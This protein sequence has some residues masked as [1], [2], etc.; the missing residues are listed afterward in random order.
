MKKN[1][2]FKFMLLLFA[3]VVGCSN[4]W[5]DEYELYSGTIT[6]GDY[7]IVYDVVAMKNTVSSSRLDYQSVTISNNKISNPGAAIVWHIAASGNY[8]TIYNANVNK[9][10]ASTGAKSKAQ[11]L[12]SG[13]DD[14]SLWTVSGTSTY[15]F[16]NKKN[17]AN[18]VNKN[19][20][21]NSGY[22]FACYATSTGGALSLYKKVEATGA[23]TTVTID[24]SELTNTNKFFGT[25]AGTLTAAVTVTSGG[26][27]VDG[28]TVTWSSGDEDVA[29]VDE[30]GVVTL[31]GEGS[32]TITAS[33][34]GETGVYKSS[35]AEYVLNVTDE[36]PFNY[37][38]WSENFGT[39]SEGDIPSGGTYS[40]VCVNGAT[41]TQIYEANMAGGT[42]PELLVNKNGGT[43][44]AT[45]PLDNI[46]GNLKLKFK[47]NAYA[48]SVSTSTDGISISGDY[49]FNTAGEHTVTFTG[50][51]PSKTSIV[52]KF[53][54]GSSN[55][56][57]DDITLKGAIPGDNN[58]ELTEDFTIPTGTTFDITS[59]FII[60]DGVTLTVNG[61]LENDDPANLII[62]DG[63]QLICN[64]PVN[65]T[66]QKGI[67]AAVVWGVPGAD[68]WYFIASPVDGYETSNVIITGTSDTD[69]YSFDE[70]SGYW[71]NGQGTEHPF[72]TLNRGQGY[73]YANKTGD[74]LS[75]LGT[76]PATNTNI[77]KTLSYAGNGD[78][79]GFNLMGNPFT[80]N[81][82]NDNVKIQYGETQTSLTT[83][84]IV[85]NGTELATMELSSNPIK[86]GRGFLIQADKDGQKLVF[87]PGAKR[88]ETIN[89]PSF[90]RIEAGD[91]DFMDR[92]YVQFGQGN[93]L[94]KMT[95]N[96]NVSHV[97]VMSEG[98]DYAAA[99]IQEAQGEMP[100]NFKAHRD[101][102]YTITVNPQEVEMDYLHLVDN[103]AGV[104]VN[105]LANPSYTFNAKG[106]DYESRF[107]LVFSANMVN[108]EM[109]EDFAFISDGQLVIAN[110]GEAIL[111][112]IDVTGRVVAN[113]NINGTCSKAINAKAGVYVLRLING[114]DV[115]TQ[116]MVI[117]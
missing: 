62:E 39:Y 81:L 96:D 64:N 10:A 54:A 58:H 2:T 79:K 68:A 87:N 51:I 91:A 108:A 13:T 12:E 83:Y 105:L 60:P 107:R 1:F 33:Y 57:I 26:A 47:S 11:L 72:N 14:M 20:R 18:N 77:E 71:F 67:E 17:D 21:Y 44:Q 59:E 86:P 93:T 61:T 116:K 16:V 22:G 74:N 36:S 49:S 70:E 19:L 52:I 109:G 4:V 69:L 104:D 32:T 63:A 101:G 46:T 43:F 23:A 111:Q 38:L 78:L 40:Y 65:A 56:R 92:A 80:C 102:Q 48:I 76:M 28:A 30:D 53:A 42:S 35:Y 66:L 99:T 117:R 15:E 88:G 82:T 3:L 27:A 45:I 9:Y 112:V 55:V 6:E 89:K 94:R 5:A 31:V 75:F 73:L 97:Y 24:D 115:K 29:T 98:K 8:W 113:E 95:I 7:V 103:I 110:V 34:A 50:I 90:I 106:D 25:A 100:V 84:Y 41:K 37:T 85:E 114:T